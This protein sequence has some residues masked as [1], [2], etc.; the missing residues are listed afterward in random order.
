MNR[1]PKRLVSALAVTALCVLP[2]VSSWAQ[3]QSL[4]PLV[5]SSSDAARPKPANSWRVAFDEGAASNGTISFRIWPSDDSPMHVDI[6]V[7]DGETDAQVA[8]VTRDVLAA[9][10]GSRYRVVVVDGVDVVVSAQRGTPDFTVELL[11]DTA[12]DVM[13]VV[14]RD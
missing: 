13:V 11:R 10:L 4:L 12:R 14:Q 8:D 3:A 5:Q 7:L 6:P 9:R 2:A 1:L